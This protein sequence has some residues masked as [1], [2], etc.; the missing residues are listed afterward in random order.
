MQRLTKEQAAIIGLY[1]GVSCGPFSDIQELAEKVL[2]CPIM[3]HQFADKW[4]WHTAKEKIRPQ[5]LAL[6]Y[7]PE[8]SPDA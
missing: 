8:V 4:I 5:F 2:G 1:T 3:V 6:C 7:D